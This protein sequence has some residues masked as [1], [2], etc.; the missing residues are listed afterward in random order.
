[1]IVWVVHFLGEDFN[2]NATSAARKSFCHSE[3]CRFHF[4]STQRLCRCDSEFLLGVIHLGESHPPLSLSLSLKNN[5]SSLVFS[6]TLGCSEYGKKVFKYHLSLHQINTCT[7]STTFS[8]SFVL[9][10]MFY[11]SI[12][13][14]TCVLYSSVYATSL[15]SVSGVVT[16][17]H[18]P[19]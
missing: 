19:C 5:I 14:V 3:L 4:G 15:A 13:G 6:V 16:C 7:V 12:C 10:S 17:N 11:H 2:L 8:C 1:M 18:F 9:H